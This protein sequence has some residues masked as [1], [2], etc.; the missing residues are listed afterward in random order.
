VPNL[1][2]IAG[3]MTDKAALK[4]ALVEQLAAEV[5]GLAASHEATLAG[6]THEEAKPESDKDTRAVE[7]SY[8]ARGQA[9]RV[10]EA[11][12]GL[13]LV[14][15]LELPRLGEG[16]RVVLGALITYRE[17][18]EEK[19]VL[20]APAGGGRK[21]SRVQVVT[22]QAPLGRALLGKRA[23]DELELLLGGKQ[24]TLEVLSVE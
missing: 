15:A 19:Q 18:D 1:V 23:G 16:A 4:R 9:A 12:A 24:R 22:P 11:E 8:L 20:L 21:L 7:Q 5:A 10:V 13:A 2:T 6:A 14:R 17:D 3:A